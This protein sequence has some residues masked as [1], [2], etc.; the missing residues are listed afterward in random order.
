M[1]GRVSHRT[2]IKSFR[3]PIIQTYALAEVFKIF[4]LALVILCLIFVMTSTVQFL[5]KGIPLVQFAEKL[6]YIILYF[7]PFI[8]PV[9]MLS[10]ITLG[11]GRMV[12]EREV[13]AM[14][15][16]GINL[17]QIAVPVIIFAFA[18][19][20]ASIYLMDEIIPFCYKKQREV[21]AEY[22]RK[23]LSLKDGT[24]EPIRWNRG[25][26][27]LGSIRGEDLRDV[28]FWQLENNQWIEF[29]ARAGKISFTPNEDAANLLLLDLVVT[30]FKNENVFPMKADWLKV[31]L[32]LYQQSAAF[33]KAM[34]SWKLAEYI[35]ALKNEKKRIQ[36]AMQKSAGAA[37][38]EAPAEESADEEKEIERTLAGGPA[39]VTQ[40]NKNNPKKQLQKADE[41]LNSARAEYYRRTPFAF[42]TLAFALLALPLTLMGQ[43]KNRLVAF[44]KAF[45][46][47][48]FICFIPLV[49]ASILAENGKV[50][51]HGALWLGNFASLAVA[52]GLSLRSGY[53]FAGMFR[54]SP[55]KPA[56]LPAGGAA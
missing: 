9:A 14:R 16:A 5:H 53:G 47:A 35:T 29:R 39:V 23:I 11:L 7:L 13:E 21:Q 51:P 46:L 22:V 12:Q 24:N 37:A 25:A 10:G 34:P 26:L 45:L 49:A 50:S 6:P 8:L 27:Y 17:V 40:Q 54:R 28:E 15:A 41:L 32:P 56:G 36:D 30:Q 4:C 33:P 38:A 2:G 20:F 44:F 48:L 31:G 1:E 42:A 3:L 43:H 19:S 18:V 52:L 55:G